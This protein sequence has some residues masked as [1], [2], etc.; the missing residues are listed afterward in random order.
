MRNSIAKRRQKLIDKLV[1]L[2]IF[3]KEDTQ[4]NELLLSELEYEYRRFRSENH[5][6]DG[7]FQWT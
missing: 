6:H 3:Q 1:A 5:P 2:N 4:L 7:A